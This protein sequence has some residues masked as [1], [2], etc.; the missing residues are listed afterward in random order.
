MALGLKLPSLATNKIGSMLP[1]LKVKPTIY[2]IIPSYS[3]CSSLA[4]DSHGVTDHTKSNG[5]R[6]LNFCPM[7]FWRKSGLTYDYI[8]PLWAE[9]RK[10]DHIVRD[11]KPPP[12]RRSAAAGMQISPAKS[13]FVRCTKNVHKIVLHIWE[14]WR[15][16]VLQL[17]LSNESSRSRLQKLAL[18]CMRLQAPLWQPGNG[19]KKLN[20]I[21]KAQGTFCGSYIYDSRNHPTPCLPCCSDPQAVAFQGL[22]FVCKV[23]LWRWKATERSKTVHRAA[24]FKTNPKSCCCG[25]FQN[26][27]S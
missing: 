26:S 8:L 12:I 17:L 24:C 6:Y 2:T 10:W 18:L 23:Q 20:I 27:H 14:P 21:L 16:F 4:P 22:S 5:N 7:V 19:K 13:W 25:L 11:N 15:I 3:P 1:F 9:L